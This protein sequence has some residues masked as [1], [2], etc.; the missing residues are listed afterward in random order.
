MECTQAEQAAEP[1]EEATEI[2]MEIVTAA[3]VVTTS[4]EFT[5]VEAV[6]E[7]VAEEAEELAVEACKDP[8]DFAAKQPAEKKKMKWFCDNHGCMVRHREESDCTCCNA[9][10]VGE[11][12]YSD[13]EY[14]DD[15]DICDPP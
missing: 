5:V 6:H 15:N 1:S 9:T 7:T 10:C 14:D 2:Q 8:E 13:E 3:E 12:F 4:N 11:A